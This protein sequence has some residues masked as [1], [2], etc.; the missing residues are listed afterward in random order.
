MERKRGHPLAHE[1]QGGYIARQ[2]AF[3]DEGILIVDSQHL[4]SERH[5]NRTRIKNEH[6]M[7]QF[8]PH[9][10]NQEIYDAVAHANRKTFGSGSS[11]PRGYSKE[12]W[13]TIKRQVKA[14]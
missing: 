8:H 2:I 7:K 4:A 9:N 14:R 3:S 10:R 5:R 6:Y 1:V 13:N 11:K 12:Y